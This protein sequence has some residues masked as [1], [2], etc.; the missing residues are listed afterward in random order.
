[1]PVGF[2]YPIRVS[3]PGLKEAPEIYGFYIERH[4]HKLG[5]D[6]RADVREEQRKDTGQ[7]RERTRIKVTSR[8]GG[9]LRSLSIY[10]TSIQAAVDETGARPHFPPYKQGT[11]LY[12]WVQRHNIGGGVL[13][14]SQRRGI[15]AQ[16][17]ASTRAELRGRFN[18]DL[19]KLFIRA[20]GQAAVAATQARLDKQTERVSFLI[21]RAQSRRG[22]PRPGDALRAPFKDVEARRR[23]YIRG[24]FALPFAL[25]TKRVNSLDRRT[26]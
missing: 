22:L 18:E 13:L 14:G 12:G 6:L 23:Q 4:L 16:G 26:A 1:M 2:R 7:E 19:R 15:A 9:M 24:S 25:A 8:R 21:A 17:R 20:G 5:D 11:K 10:N 3:A